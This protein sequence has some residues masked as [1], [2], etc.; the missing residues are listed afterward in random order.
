LADLVQLVYASR[1]FGF[2]SAILS[3]ILLTARANNAR[4]DITGCLIC[5]GDLYLQLL[6]GPPAAIEALYGQIR[7]DDRHLEVRELLRRTVQ[8]RMFPGWAM[9]D[10]PVQSWMWTQ[11][12]VDAGA[13]DRA[14]EGEILAIFAR[15]GG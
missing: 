12:E 10:D 15:V 5:R 14:S 13:V 7:R 9:R 6:E 11:D 4:D 8:E 1:P 2:D 3:G